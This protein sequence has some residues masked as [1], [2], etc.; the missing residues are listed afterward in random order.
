MSDP[1]KADECP[2]GLSD[3][4]FTILIGEV[5]HPLHTLTLISASFRA[6]TILSISS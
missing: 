6:T 3:W 2:Q 4:E 1:L 5:I